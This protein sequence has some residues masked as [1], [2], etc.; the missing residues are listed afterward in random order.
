MDSKEIIRELEGHGIRPTANRI[1][2][3]EAL[4]GSKGP[5]SMVEIEGLIPTIDKSGI[6]RTLMAFKEKHL[7]HS[8]ESEDGIRYELCHS[9]DPHHDDDRHVHFYCERCH[10]TFC[11]ETI[12]LPQVALPEGYERLS[13]NY[14]IRGL[15]PD[16]QRI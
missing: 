11:L 13:A 3:A 8:V 12:P 2:I 6:F 7:V 4:S 5:M 16:C 1:L 14:L 15:C 10:R 9:H